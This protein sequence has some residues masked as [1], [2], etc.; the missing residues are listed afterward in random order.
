MANRLGERVRELRRQRGFS[1]VHTLSRVAGVG[2]Q[3]LVNLERYNLPP[4]RRATAERIA[5]AGLH[6]KRFGLARG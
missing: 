3:V 1:S 5:R 4:K 6:D 2:V